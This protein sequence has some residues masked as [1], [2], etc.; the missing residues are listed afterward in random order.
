ML[1]VSLFN[2]N[3]EV[4]FFSVGSERENT[5]GIENN[6]RRTA[7]VKA[8]ALKSQVEGRYKKNYEGGRNHATNELGVR[9]HVK[10][11][12]ARM[13]KKGVDSSPRWVTD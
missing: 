10:Q 13:V 6:K 2:E 9:Q 12:H 7:L 8:P 11:I 4:I 3:Q 1:A 5:G